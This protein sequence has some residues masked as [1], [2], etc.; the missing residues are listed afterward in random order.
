MP[1]VYGQKKEK[2]RKMKTASKLSFASQAI[3]IAVGI[4]GIAAICFWAGPCDGA[5]E[6]ANGNMAPMRCAY[7]AKIAILILAMATAISIKGLSLGRPESLALILLGVALVAITFESLVGIG[8]CKS[9]MMCW[10]MA[11]W[12]R[13]CGVVIAACGA[14]NAV[15]AL[16]GKQVR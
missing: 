8:V 1:A 4:I 5:L 3:A 15:S 10:T 14:A 9:E 12:I 6:L 2:G 13:P 7:T 11:A 16:I